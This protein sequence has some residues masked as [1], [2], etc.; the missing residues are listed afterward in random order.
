MEN[1]TNVDFNE[2]IESL[3]NRLGVNDVDDELYRKLILQLFSDL[4]P[5]VQVNIILKSIAN[6]SSLKDE[7]SLHDIQNNIFLYFIICIFITLSSIFI[8]IAEITKIKLNNLST[9]DI[10]LL[11]ED[12]QHFIT[13]L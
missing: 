1:G 12:I 2:L 4:Q 11:I 8:F 3:R 7:E 10:E 13:T 5:A 6:S 9:G